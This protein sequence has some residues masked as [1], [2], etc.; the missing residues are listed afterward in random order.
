MCVPVLLG[1]RTRVE[2]THHLRAQHG[3]PGVPVSPV[4]G[5]WPDPRRTTGTQRGVGC[6]WADWSTPAACSSPT[7]P[8]LP[9]SPGGAATSPQSCPRPGWR[10]CWPHPDPGVLGLGEGAL[11]PSCRAGGG[12]GAVQRGCAEVCS[13][14]PPREAAGPLVLRPLRRWEGSRC[15]A[16]SCTCLPASAPLCADKRWGVEASWVLDL[17]SGG[18]QGR[19]QPPV[20]PTPV[21]AE[22]AGGQVSRSCH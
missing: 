12:R 7:T 19:P 11:G 21:P 2:V 5:A 9:E 1:H 8:P 20:P 14:R 16:G 10:A 13:F 15:L 22:G 17:L 3:P 6:G 4:P 18:S